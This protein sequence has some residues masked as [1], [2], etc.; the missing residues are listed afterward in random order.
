MIQ[1]TL[2]DGRTVE[3]EEN[4]LGWMS[5]DDVL[6]EAANAIA[7]RGGRK[8]FWGFMPNPRL[9]EADEVA[10]ELGGRI[11]R[12]TDPAPPPDEDRG[13]QRIIY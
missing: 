1:I 3:L 13:D 6:T 11:T 4:A 9:L 8:R 12:N 10:K 7:R 5:T 2:Q